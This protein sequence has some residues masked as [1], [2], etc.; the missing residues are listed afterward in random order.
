MNLMTQ[1]DFIKTF[2]SFSAKDRRAIARKIHVRVLDDLFEELDAEMPDVNLSTEEVQEEINAY[3]N[4]KKA[5]N[6]S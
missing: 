6:R 4:E 3:R 1:T 5:Q 2:E